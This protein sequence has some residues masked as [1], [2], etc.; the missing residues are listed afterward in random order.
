M[1]R[2]HSAAPC[3]SLLLTS[4]AVYRLLQLVFHEPLVEAI[5]TL[6]LQPGADRTILGEISPQMCEIRC[7][8]TAVRVSRQPFV[9]GRSECAW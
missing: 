1:R 6:G 8:A 7:A 4:L 3:P 2:T 9:A 5:F